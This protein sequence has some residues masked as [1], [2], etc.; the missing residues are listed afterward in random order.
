MDVV[1]P[2][3]LYFGLMI[4]SGDDIKVIRDKLVLDDG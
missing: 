1:A 4:F 2:S 3:Q